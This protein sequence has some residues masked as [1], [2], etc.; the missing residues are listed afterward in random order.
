MGAIVTI[1]GNVAVKIGFSVCVTVA[2]IHFENP[3][4]LWW[5]LLLLLLGFSYESHEKK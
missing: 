4:L 5:Y 1:L 3:R 2:A